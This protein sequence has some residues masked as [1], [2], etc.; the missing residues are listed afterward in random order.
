M[1]A[2]N[3]SIE[4]QMGFHTRREKEENRCGEGHIH[5]S[6]LSSFISHFLSSS[7]VYSAKAEHTSPTLHTKT[8]TDWRTPDDWNQLH[9]ELS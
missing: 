6:P 5:C 3:G 8:T 7:S 2:W 1:I 9:F 4:E